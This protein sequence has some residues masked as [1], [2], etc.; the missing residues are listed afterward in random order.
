MPRG[1]HASR[2][3][4]TKVNIRTNAPKTAHEAPVK[5]CSTNQVRSA[6][7]PSLRVAITNPRSV[8]GCEYASCGNSSSA[9][10]MPVMFACPEM[11][12]SA[13][14]AT[15]EHCCSTTRQRAVAFKIGSAFRASSRPPMMDKMTPYTPA[16]AFVGSFNMLRPEGKRSARVRHRCESKGA[17]SMRQPRC[18]RSVFVVEKGLTETA[19]QVF[20]RR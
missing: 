20:Q 18:T 13:A 11:T 14:A 10:T 2:K 9:S 3:Y 4:D 6:T 5:G 1:E 19:D 8:K 17:A 15:L 16:D 7:A 12:A